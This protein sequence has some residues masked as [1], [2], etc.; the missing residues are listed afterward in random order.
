MA[1]VFEYLTVEWLWD[2]SSLRITHPHQ[3][4]K[5]IQGSYQEVVNL[6]TSLGKEGW[7]VCACVANSNWLFWTLKK[8]N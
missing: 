8:E 1:K 2:S 7:E 4:E 5:S 3:P 6:L